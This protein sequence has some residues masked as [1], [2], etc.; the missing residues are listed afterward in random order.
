MPAQDVTVTAHFVR[1][2]NLTMAVSPSGAG[3]TTPSGTT[4]RVAGS[5]INIQAAPEA[6]YQFL[7]WSAPAGTFGNPNSPTTTFT[8][9][10]QDVT[11]TA[12]FVKALGDFTC[13]WTNLWTAP[14]IGELVDLED[15]FVSIDDAVVEWAIG[16]AN[17]AEKWYE[18]VLYPISSPD[19]HFTIYLIDYQGEPQ[20][21][22]VV[23]QNQFG[24]QS[25]NVT[26]PVALA[27]PTQ[28][29]GHEPPEG[30]D[31]YLLYRVIGG[32]PLE[33]VV[34]LDDQFGQQA[35]IVVYEPILF[36]NPVKKTHGQ[37]VAEIE[38]PITHFV[39]Y[40]MGY[41]YF[42]RQVQVTNQFG[43]YALEIWDSDSLAV[44]S[45]KLSYEPIQ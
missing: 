25:L 4:A 31:H 11:V 29:E 15:Q 42:D 35:D 22:E 23:V 27:V 45:V 14:N 36:A 39:I 20:S 17:P 34:T 40:A 5:V 19:D 8:M 12:H 7:N 41:R 37:Y 1:L 13:Y 3:T 44:S 16:F 26:G 32:S 10:A 24:T 2:Y 38:N 28:K 33:K 21:W 18:E 9:P 6:G 30:L 43:E